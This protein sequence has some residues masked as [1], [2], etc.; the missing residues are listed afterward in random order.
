MSE[1]Q[2]VTVALITMFVCTAIGLAS[3]TVGI[4]MLGGIVLAVLIYNAKPKE[5]G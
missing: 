1:D 4:S 5:R 2:R 3:D